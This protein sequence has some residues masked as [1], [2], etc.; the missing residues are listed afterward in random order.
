MQKNECKGGFEESATHSYHRLKGL[1]RGVQVQASLRAGEMI[2]A[3][4]AAAA[5]R[6]KNVCL[7]LRALESD[8]ESKCCNFT[9]LLQCLSSFVES[10]ARTCLFSR[11]NI[12]IDF[13][14][15]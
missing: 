14:R 6:A 13:W 4:E 15:A 11:R 8:G 9:N 5:A 3:Q 2:Q 1:S 10:A 7:S 12:T